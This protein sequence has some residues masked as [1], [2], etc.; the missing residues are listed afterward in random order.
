[1]SAEKKYTERDMVEAER[2]AF[3]KG[4]MR[5]VIL[6]EALGF[7]QKYIAHRA[8]TTYPLP[9][10]ARPRV[11]IMDGTGW[12]CIGARLEWQDQR[13][14]WTASGQFMPTPKLVALWADLI[15][16]PTEEVDA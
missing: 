10:V 15:A 11:V 13:T 5:D 8:N 6:D 14:P 9:K 16:N 12:R 3:T 4:W 2:A 1:M 7:D